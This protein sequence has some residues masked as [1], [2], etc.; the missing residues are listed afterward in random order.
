MYVPSNVDK[1][2]VSDKCKCA[3]SMG[4]IF[5]EVLSLVSNEAAIFV[6]LPMHSAMLPTGGCATQSLQDNVR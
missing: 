1:A 5:C 6:Y 4:I 2:L 3:V